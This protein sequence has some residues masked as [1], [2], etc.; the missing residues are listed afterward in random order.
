MGEQIVNGDGTDRREIYT[1]GHSNHSIEQFIKLLRDTGITVV[2]DVRSVPY[3]RRMP[4]FSRSDL[5]R[6]LS[7]AGIAYVFLGNQL[8]ARPKDRSSYRH[9]TADYQVIIA[10]EA[11]RDG[12]E[13]VEK[14]AERYRIALMC[15]ERDP[16]DCHRTIL[17]AR[18]LQE[19]G[20]A[21]KHVLADGSIERNE[22][23]EKRLLKLTKLEAGDLFA[24]PQ[25]QGDPVARAYEVRGREIAYKEEQEWGGDVGTRASRQTG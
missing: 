14:G 21:I 13:R 20:A 8:G 1:I 3:S 9:G 24:S 19:R 7:K 4:H 12:L 17:V 23:T 22:E 11:F 25:E 10:T 15:A 2:A 16:L 18:R 5:K 6:S